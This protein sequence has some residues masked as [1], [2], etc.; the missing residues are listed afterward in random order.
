MKDFSE[1]N[2]SIGVKVMG[3]VES[4]KP[5]RREHNPE[6][7]QADQEGFIYLPNVNVVEEMANMISASR[8]Y[9]TNVEVMNS[10][11]QMLM[12]T[13]AIGQ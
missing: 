5:L 13:L 1:E 9:Q 7:P 2:P 4:Q 10:A 6:H 8:A 3:V 12:R 11:K